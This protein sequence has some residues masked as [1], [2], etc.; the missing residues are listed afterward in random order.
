[1]TI[2]D[3]ITRI[4]N[5][6]QAI[7]TAIGAKGVEVPDTEL[8]STYH[9]YID[10]IKVSSPVTDFK[11]AVNAGTAQT[12]YPV[13]TEISDTYDG[14]DNPLIVAQ[15][16]DS[17]NNSAYGGAE[18]AI[19]I[20]KFVEPTSLAFGDSVDYETSAIRTLLNTTYYNNCSDDLKSVLSNISVPYYNGSS[21]TTVTDRVF[22]MSTYEVCNQGQGAAYYEGAMWDYWKQKTGL[23]LP[24]AVEVNND[25]RIMESRDGDAERVWLRSRSSSTV[26]YL[27]NV[28]GAINSSR[29]SY[30][31][32][33]VLPAFFIAKE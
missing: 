19:L 14:N 24:D 8:I 9:T 28:R 23:S 29:P 33:S 6:K 22:L 15:Y 11:A 20:R 17:T 21:M 16:L 2:A 30:S 7:K 27:V 10:Q 13:G 3:E 5:A 26:V 4:N 18:G 25:G 12:D 32:S 1:M 31:T